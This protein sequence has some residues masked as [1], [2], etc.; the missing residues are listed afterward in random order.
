RPAHIILLDV[1]DAEAKGDTLKAKRLNAEHDQ[2]VEY[3]ELKETRPE[4]CW[5]LGVGGKTPQWGKVQGRT[6][7][8]LGFH[9]GCPEGEARREVDHARWDTYLQARD[10]ERANQFRRSL[11]S[12][13]RGFT[14]GSYP[15]TAEAQ[16]TLISHVTQFRDR[17]LEFEGK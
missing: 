5:C 4:G 15:L 6:Y 13:F 14:L 10:K 16:K 2:A 3:E 17:R 11:P 9:C 7:T 12:R 8:W 1:W